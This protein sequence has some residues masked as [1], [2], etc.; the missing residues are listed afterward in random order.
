MMGRMDTQPQAE[1]TEPGLPGK[2][3]SLEPFSATL[4]LSVSALIGSLQDSGKENMATT[5]APS[6][7]EV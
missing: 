3:K 6:T 1:D 7:L 5:S 2:E 4:G